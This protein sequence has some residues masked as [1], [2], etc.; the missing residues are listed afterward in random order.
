[1][2][3]VAL[4]GAGGHAS[5][6]LSLLESFPPC[7][8]HNV[9]GLFHSDPET[10]DP[11]RF[12]GRGVVLRSLDELGDVIASTD[13]LRY[14][15]AVGYPDA[16]RDVVDLASLAGI[17]PLTAVHATAELGTGV[18]LGS[19]V[20]V[21]AQTSIS[22]LVGIGDHAYVSH[23]A[24]VGHDT[25]V[26]AYTSLMPGSSVSGDCIIGDGV[27]IGSNATIL[28]KIKVG[29][30]AVVAAGAVVTK[31]VDPGVLVVGAPARPMERRVED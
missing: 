22:P 19:G 27:M 13:E 20:V 2:V 31:D 28:E 24:L 30:G 23:G 16:R 29:A 8:A 6:V 26:G 3:D 14:I 10:I 17:I 9:V 21:L 5:D 11:R 25:I 18:S 7:E 1:M 15:A 12:V 4:I